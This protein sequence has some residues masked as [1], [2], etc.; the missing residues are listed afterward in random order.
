MTDTNTP[1]GPLEL[2]DGRWA[3]G[4]S[5]RPGGSWV[6]FRAE[7]L[8]RCAREAE[9][10]L[11]PWS[12][13][14]LGMRLTL[15]G[16]YPSK[17]MYTLVGLLAGLLGL[18]GRGGGYL[19]MTLRHPY[20][21]QAVYFDRHTRR[22]RGAELLLLEELLTQTVAA[23]EAQRLGDAEWLGR[24]VGHLTPLTPWTFGR[25]REA[26]TQARQVASAAGS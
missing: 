3:V 15:G 20:E 25:L 18:R 6:E 8:C 19:H 22:Y 10:E 5:R 2:A 17:D 23:G 16:R 13:T 21:D 26:V 11:I 9:G 12:R 14:M 4:D 24:A 1:L 7:G